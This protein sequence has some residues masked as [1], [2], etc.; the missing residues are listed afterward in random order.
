MELSTGRKILYPYLMY[1]YFGIE[2]SITSLFRR[3]R[4]HELLVNST[5]KYRP[6]SVP[7][8]VHNGNIWTEF[9]TFNDKPFLSDP[10]CLV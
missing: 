4:I 8:D 6:S 5:E 3:N 2:N 1:C 9:Q 10:L 7:T